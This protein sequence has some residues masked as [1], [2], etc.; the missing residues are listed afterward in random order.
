MNNFNSSNVC[1]NIGGCDYKYNGQLLSGC[2]LL[3]TLI[4]LLFYNYLMRGLWL[5]VC[6]NGLKYFKSRVRLYDWRIVLNLL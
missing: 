1:Q 6:N 2:Y 5:K 4:M 3:R